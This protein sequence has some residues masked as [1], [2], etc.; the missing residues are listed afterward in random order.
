MGDPGQRVEEPQNREV[1]ISLQ[2]EIVESG[3]TQ[4]SL[5]NEI[6]ESGKTLAIE[7]LTS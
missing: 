5:Q 6:V 1:K 7:D 4:I 2:N 3:K